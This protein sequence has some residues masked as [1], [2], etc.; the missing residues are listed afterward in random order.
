M[1]RAKDMSDFGVAASAGAILQVK[2]AHL[3][4]AFSDAV[5][6]SLQYITGLS[7]DITPTSTSSKFLLIANIWGGNNATASHNYLN[8][9]LQEINTAR[10]VGSYV[11]TNTKDPYGYALCHVMTAIDEPNT[12]SECN[13][14]VGYIDTSVSGGTIYINQI[15][16]GAP[17]AR[18]ELIVME[19]VQ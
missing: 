18:S 6:T 1:T 15:Y 13:Y 16:G 3:D 19:I 14:K 2:N 17:V 11:Q 7:V 10:Q 9:R 5:S 12:T 8:L 4:T